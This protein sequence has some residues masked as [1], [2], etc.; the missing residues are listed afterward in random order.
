MKF[1]RLASVLPSFLALWCVVSLARPATA[2]YIYLDTNGNGI[3]DALDALDLGGP[4]IVDVWLD[5]QHNRDGTL[6][7]CANGAGPLDIFSYEFILR[8]DNGTVSW[9]NYT[10]DM[11][12]TLDFGQM[13]SSGE[14]F[15]TRG[16][17]TPPIAPGLYRLGSLQIDVLSGAPTI[18]FART[19][20]LRP[21]TG[22][23]FGSNCTGVN[24]NNTIELG[25][26]FFDADGTAPRLNALVTA[27]GDGDN[28]NFNANNWTQ[29]C[30]TIKADAGSFDITN[31]DVGSIQM[32]SPGT[33]T[34]KAVPCG[35][36]AAVNL[37][38]QTMT[39]CFTR[40]Q[41]IQLFCDV[42]GSNNP[43]TVT[44]TGNLFGGGTF[45]GTIA[46]KVSFGTI[47]CVARLWPNPVTNESSLE[48]RTF[49]QGFIHVGIYDVRGRLVR[50]L[51]T[52]KDALPGSRTLAVQRVDA[53]GR[54]LPSGIYFY[55]VEVPGGSARGRFT[56]LK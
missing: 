8:A 2:Q 13:S 43:V 3:H 42:A 35:K 48:V 50:R 26:D 20:T 52:E 22:T 24:Y 37:Q 18:S 56:V 47:N 9:S 34:V 33:G 17:N 46:L 27:K 23:R 36:T 10:D 4:T 38:D 51:L 28:I 11:L 15:V 41:L 25:V 19:T 7:A 49:Q 54:P 32:V 39:V 40:D 21:S 5:T 45:S 14:F 16:S 1:P 29:K 44:V 30:V 55:K 6:A 31:V 53:A 12:F